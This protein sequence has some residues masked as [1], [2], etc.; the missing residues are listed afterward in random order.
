MKADNHNTPKLI[1]LELLK[2]YS[3]LFE[4]LLLTFVIIVLMILIRI[5]IPIFYSPDKCFDDIRDHKYFIWMAENP[6]VILNNQIP[7]PWCYRI[8]Y[9]LIIWLLP[10]ELII[11]F[12]IITYI[13]TFLTGVVLYTIFR[14]KFNSLLGLVGIIFYYS[15]DYTLY[16]QFYNIWIPD[17]LAHLL[18]ALSFYAILNSNYKLYSFSLVIGV[19][20][21]E[22]ILFTIPVF[23][24]FELLK[25][26][27]IAPL[28]A[29]YLKKSFV[30]IL[31]SIF[32]FFF[33][34]IL[35][36]PSE[37]FD[38]IEKFQIYSSRFYDLLNPF[39]A[40]QNI[41]GIWGIPIVIFFVFNSC[42]GLAKWIIRYIPF[43]FIVYLQMFIAPTISRLLVIGFFPVIL[44]S[45]SGMDNLIII[46]RNRIPKLKTSHYGQY[47]I[48]LLYLIIAITYFI[49]KLFVR[50]LWVGNGY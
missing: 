42:K 20:T 44:L 7:A 34:R 21:K 48:Y 35:I 47:L 50:D 27:K 9:P 30:G 28:Q 49:F 8:L 4:Y 39:W 41:I 5:T 31:P 14:N 18:M 43:M 46:M 10:F 24:L 11:N 40:Y 37:H 33:V 17:S 23:L 3:K 29:E 6:S 1:Y 2:R 19:L 22:V 25:M 38:Y 45:L 26:E 16:N 13:C 12:Q 36:I 32:I 15:Y